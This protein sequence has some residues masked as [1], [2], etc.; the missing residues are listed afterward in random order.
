MTTEAL[1]STFSNLVVCSWLSWIWEPYVNRIERHSSDSAKDT[2]SNSD[3]TYNQWWILW[4]ISIIKLL[5]KWKICLKF[6]FS[7][8]FQRYQGS[9]GRFKGILHVQVSKYLH[10]Y[11]IKFIIDLEILY[12][13]SSEENTRFGVKSY[14]FCY[15]PHYF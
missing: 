8:V 4:N 5:C 11:T 3:I 1:N 9:H 14:G 10:T 13:F 7:I 12:S 6:L 2:Y 15:Y